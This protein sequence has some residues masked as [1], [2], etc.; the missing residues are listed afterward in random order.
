MAWLLSPCRTCCATFIYTGSGASKIAKAL[1][2][3]VIKCRR[4]RSKS[5][6]RC[7]S[8][9]ARWVNAP[10]T[11]NQASNFRASGHLC[12]GS[13][14]RRDRLGKLICGALFQVASQF[15]LLEMVSPTVTPEHGVRN[16][17]RLQYV[18]PRK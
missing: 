18:S 15:N 3:A 2:A 13:A 16:V 7:R 14:L 4:R 9:K 6:V 12:G 8:G 1:S 17:G 11:A 10:E 5:F